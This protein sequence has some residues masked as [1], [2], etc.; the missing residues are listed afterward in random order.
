MITFTEAARAQVLK[1]MHDQD[2]VNTALRISVVGR[3]PGGYRYHLEFAEKNQ[4]T[5]QDTVLNAGGFDVLVDAE[6]AANLK[7]ALVHFIDGIEGSG[8]KIEN[9]NASWA[10]PVARAVQEVI[11]TRVN[12][13]VSAHGGRVTLA[14]VEGD[15]AYI[16]F[17]GGCHGC[18]MVDVTLKQGIEATI[19]EAVPAIKRVV[20]ITDHEQGENPY[21][22]SS[23]GRS[24]FPGGK[25][26][27]R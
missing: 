11:D 10:S 6:S 14:N 16:S 2:R 1:I 27:E 4:Q 3:G 9:P 5:P 24:P 7:G 17:G 26:E 8:F 13:A 20:D 19:K 12:P 15:A 21:Y 22:R 18:G 23:D 25:T